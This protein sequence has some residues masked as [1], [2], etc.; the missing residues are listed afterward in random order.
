MPGVL[1]FEAL[2]AQAGAVAILS[3][4]QNRGKIA[5]FGGI[6]EAKFR[7]KVRQEYAASGS[8]FRQTEKQSRLW[9]ATAY[10]GDKIACPMRDYVRYRII[11]ER[12]WR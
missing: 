3:M 12:A 4:E 2:A 11:G 7:Q 10:L 5:Y 9:K 8:G 6:K 1:I